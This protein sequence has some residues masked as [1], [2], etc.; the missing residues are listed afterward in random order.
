MDI[1]NEIGTSVCGT[2][3]LLD[4]CA[5]LGLLEKI[6]EGDYFS[7]YPTAYSTERHAGLEEML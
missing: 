5:A 2:E 4:A 6:S 3:R 7:S 1:A